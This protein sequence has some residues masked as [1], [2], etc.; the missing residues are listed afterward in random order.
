MISSVIRHESDEIL[1]GTTQS[2]VAAVVQIKLIFQ[3]H[4]LLL[5]TCLMMI[6]CLCP[7]EDMCLGHM[8]R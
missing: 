1:L 6:K 5:S 3:W 8:L 2:T 4:S 7:V